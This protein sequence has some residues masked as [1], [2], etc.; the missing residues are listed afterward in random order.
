MKTFLAFAVGLSILCSCTPA[1]GALSSAAPTL[2]TQARA[3]PVVPAGPLRD[4]WRY[5]QTLLPPSDPNTYANVLLDVEPLADGGWVVIQ[6]RAP[7]RRLRQPGSLGGPFVPTKGIV[8]RLDA[9]GTIV[10]RQQDADVFAPTRLVLFERSGVVVA[11][12]SGTRGMDLQTLGTL[13]SSDA[14]CVDV[15]GRCYAYRPNV[16]PPPGAMEERDPRTFSVVRGFPQIQIGQLTTPMILPDW[17]LAIARSSSP[18]RSFDFFPLD[19]TAAIT[20]PWIDRLKTAKSIVLLSSD[21]VVV[22]YEGWG[23]GRFPKTELIDL[24]TGHVITGFGDWLPVFTNSSVTYLQ[25]ATPLQVLDPRDG[26]LGPRL[27]TLPLYV[28][29]EKG[30]VVVPLGNGGAAVLRREAAHGLEYTT[31]IMKF[32]DRACASIEFPRV[33]LADGTADCATLAGAAGGHRILV[34]IGRERD[35]D[36]FEITSVSV[37]EA[38]RRLTIGVRLGGVHSNN[39]AERAP[40]QVIEL[41]ESL[42]GR[43]LVGIE[44][45]PEAPRPFGFSTAFAIDLR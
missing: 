16:L 12:G 10:A 26:S 33:Q 40:A 45:E 24:P 42:R 13:W 29:L 28:D 35:T 36:M 27:S 11:E 4:V 20:L 32:A 41:P 17:N 22:S 37:D 39:S 34:S 19:P 3:E 1:G 15:G 7:V 44:P 25:T 38:A 2:I 5:T 23:S 18:D 6:D 43:W 21:R 9:S 14:E 30:I 31:A 8:L